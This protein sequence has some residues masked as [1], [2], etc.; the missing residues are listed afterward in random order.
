VHFDPPRHSTARRECRCGESPY[1]HISL[2]G[3]LARESVIGKHKWRK[4]WPTNGRTFWQ[5]VDAEG[6]RRYVDELRQELIKRRGGG[7]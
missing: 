5:Y 2:A 4:I 7:T 6:K 1:Y 3:S